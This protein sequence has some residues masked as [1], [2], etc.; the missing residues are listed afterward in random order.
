MLVVLC[1][2]YPPFCSETPQETYRKVMNWK[3][4]LVFPPEVPISERAKDL[5]LKY[6]KMHFHFSFLFLQTH[7]KATCHTCWCNVY[8][9]V[10]RTVILPAAVCV[11]QVLH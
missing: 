5:I 4:T 6:V 2:G 3:E 10:Y 7:T 1:P 9:R 11:L 8:I